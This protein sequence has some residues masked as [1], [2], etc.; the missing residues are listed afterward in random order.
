MVFIDSNRALWEQGSSQLLGRELIYRHLKFNSDF[1]V[2]C[3]PSWLNSSA[4]QVR[5]SFVRALALCLALLK[6][7]AAH[8]RRKRTA[9][10]KQGRSFP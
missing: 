6:T 7:A 9:D 10:R 4:L 3:I 1:D 5:P 2:D 8:Y